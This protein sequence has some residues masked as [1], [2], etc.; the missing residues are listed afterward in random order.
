MPWLLEYHE[1]LLEAEQ[2]SGVDDENVVLG[3]VPE[4]S[5]AVR[6]RPTRGGD[7]ELGWAD[8]VQGVQS[9]VCE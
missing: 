8:D 7:L 2:T 1:K 4:P 9:I 3:L 6:E 5:P